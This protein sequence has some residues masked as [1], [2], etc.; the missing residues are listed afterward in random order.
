MRVVVVGAGFAGLACADELSR[1]GHEV[2]VFEARDRVGGRVWS[3]TVDGPLGSAVVERG[4]EFVLDGYDVQRALCARFGL[5][6]ADTGMSYYVREPRGGLGT[7]VEAMAR[8]SAGLVDAVARAGSGATVPDVLAGLGLAPEVQEAL[9][10]RIE[11]S[12][13]FPAEGLSAEVLGWAASFAGLPSGRIVGGN[14]GVATRLAQSLGDAVRLSTPARGI[15]WD[16]D[17]V[18]VRTDDGEVTADYAVVAI[19]LPLV[20]GLDLSP[21]FP[22]WKA[23][24]IGRVAYGHAA[25]L[26]VPLR[27]PAPTSAVMATADRYWSWTLTAGAAEALPAV[28]CFAGSAPA[29]DRLRVS[30]GAQT[31]AKA[32][33]ALRPELDLELDAALLTT[34]TD[35]P[36][37]LGAYTAEGLASRSGDD[38]LLAEPVGPVH[39]AGEWT[40][41]DLAGLMEGALRSGLRAAAEILAIPREA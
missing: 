39:V 24:A 31:W 8:G 32:L 4:A 12:S 15:T 7:T 18:V 5:E 29:L 11:I 23:E 14:Q 33:A 34:W 19:P 41:G 27:T 17:G 6:V 37:A 26:H 10:A 20:A 35:D 9:Q 16:D 36:W 3:S 30:D 38:E 40:A 21:G 1:A 13:A 22:S 2:V 25:K 28:H